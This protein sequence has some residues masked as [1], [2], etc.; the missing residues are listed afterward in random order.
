MVPEAGVPFQA[1]RTARLHLPEVALHCLAARKGHWPS[2]WVHHS[3]CVACCAFWS[4][5]ITSARFDRPGVAQIPD[6]ASAHASHGSKA[7]LK[8]QRDEREEAEG[9]RRPGEHRKEEAEVCRCEMGSGPPGRAARSLDSFV[10]PALS[11]ARACCRVQE[12]LAKVKRLAELVKAE[13]E[14]QK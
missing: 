9:G 6:F 5:N 13:P 7:S 1:A 4:R 2:D 10:A 12:I 8:Q 3:G 11:P 14:V